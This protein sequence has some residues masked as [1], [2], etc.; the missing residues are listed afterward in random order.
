MITVVLVRL[1]FPSGE[2]APVTIDQAT[3]DGIDWCPAEFA[4]S[5]TAQ[6]A[7]LAC[8]SGDGLTLS[9]GEA[10]PETEPVTVQAPGPIRGSPVWSADGAYVGF[11]IEGDTSQ[12]YLVERSGAEG[13]RAVQGAEGMRMLLQGSGPD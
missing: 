6:G 10:A 2:S 11:W 12:L 4:V 9:L 1:L 8:V 7:R 3:I 13:V 5:S